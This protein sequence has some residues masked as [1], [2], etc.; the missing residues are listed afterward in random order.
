[1]EIL[2]T[3]LHRFPEDGNFAMRAGWVALLTGNP[4]R[5]YQFLQA[6]QR[7]GFPEEKLENA[8]ALLAIAAVQNGA[9][10]DAAVYYN[11][12]LIIAPEWQDPATLESLAWPEELKA[13]LRELAW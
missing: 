12:L 10:D 9:M 11:D 4:E 2:T 6:G 13:S 8:M 3:G 1:M 7:I 5:A